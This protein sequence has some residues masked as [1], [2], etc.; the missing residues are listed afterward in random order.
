MTKMRKTRLMRKTS[1]RYER[2][3]R[4]IPKA[5]DTLP[6]LKTLKDDFLKDKNSSGVVNTSLK[7]WD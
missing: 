1:Q 3:Q 2:C 6:K 4:P 7:E 5:E